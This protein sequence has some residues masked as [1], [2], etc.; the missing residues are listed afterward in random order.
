MRYAAEPFI[1]SVAD[2]SPGADRNY[3]HFIPRAYVE[4]FIRA[5]RR[6]RALLVLDLQPGRQH[7]LPQAKHFAWALRKPWVGL[8]LDPEWR[9]GPHQVPGQSIGSVSAAEVNRFSHFV[10][11]VTRGN[12]LPQKVFMV[13][14]FR[15]E[16]VR[17]IASVVV[18][19]PLATIQHIDGSAP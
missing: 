2:R 15:R 12:N 5:A 17:N 14:Q 16:M 6:N 3:S 10:A 11:R 13:H 7:F 4:E 18:R 19:S 8:A 1:A 9:M